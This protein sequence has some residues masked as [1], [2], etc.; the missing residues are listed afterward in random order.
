MPGCRCP[1][2]NSAHWSPMHPLSAWPGPG[3]H[4]HATLLRCSS[5]DFQGLNKNLGWAVITFR[6]WSTLCSSKISE[7]HIDASHSRQPFI[8]G[9][10]LVRYEVNAVMILMLETTCLQWRKVG[11]NKYSLNNIGWGEIVTYKNNESYASVFQGFTQTCSFLGR[12]ISKCRKLLDLA[13]RWSILLI[14]WLATGV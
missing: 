10:R 4:W 11:Q 1:N 8:K 5:P 2:P 7:S 14:Q 6:S 12:P 13:N 3:C 9:K